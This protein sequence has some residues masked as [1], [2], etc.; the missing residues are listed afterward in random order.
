MNQDPRQTAKNSGETGFFKLLNNANFRYDCRNN[1]ENCKFLLIFD[2]LNKIS[3]LKKYY[4][5]FDQNVSK[6]VSGELLKR[7]NDENFNDEM[8]KTKKDDPFQDINLTSLKNKTKEDLEALPAFE[9]KQERR[10]CKWSIKDYMT[11]H[12]EAQ[13]DNK[14]KAMIDFE[15]KQQIA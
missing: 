14:I 7:E 1:L 11:R 8:M 10:N 13:K 9:Q 2:E 6:F 3:H 4:N 12:E 5:V 15:D